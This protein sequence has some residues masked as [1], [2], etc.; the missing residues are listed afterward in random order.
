VEQI[1]QEGLAAADAA[2]EVQPADVVVRRSAEHLAE[3]AL[4]RG[5]LQQRVVQAVEF[6]QRFGL[7]GIGV[8]VAAL[9]AFAVPLRRPRRRTCLSH[10][11]AAG[12]GAR[13]S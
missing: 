12:T 10:A 13:R 7:R 3:Q 2:P 6:A 4:A 9:D 5:R 1:D 8:P 11:R